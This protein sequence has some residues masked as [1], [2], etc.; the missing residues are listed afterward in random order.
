MNFVEISSN[1]KK[2]FILHRCPNQKFIADVSAF[3]NKVVPYVQIAAPFQ[4][5][6]VYVA[7]IICIQ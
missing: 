3:L 5:V 4:V 2:K 1:S 6:N 7:F